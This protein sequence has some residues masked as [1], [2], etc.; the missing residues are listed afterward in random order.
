MKLILTATL[1]ILPFCFQAQFTPFLY[2][3]QVGARMN[4]TVNQLGAQLN[5]NMH[6]NI[7]SYGAAVDWQM[8]KL[9]SKWRLIHSVGTEIF[10]GEPIIQSGYN[11]TANY[12]IINK[13]QRILSLGVRS[14]VNAGSWYNNKSQYLLAL[15]GAH[16]SGHFIEAG[17]NAGHLF[18]RDAFG[19][20]NY[21][22]VLSG[23]FGGSFYLLDRQFKI[24][25]RIGSTYY[26]PIQSITQEIRWKNKFMIG[27][28]FGYEHYS[29]L[30]GA[31]LSNRIGIYSY[32]TQHK[33]FAEYQS[34]GAQIRMNLKAK[35]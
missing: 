35:N 5:T 3:S 33:N 6:S 27:Y 7:S 13:N 14:G 25:T 34:V 29:L 1:A 32:F 8:G 26:V 15:G 21:P 17:V 12:A 2:R 16:Y 30:V 18:Y 9:S 10:P 24:T 23:Y 4:D 22:V 19:N 31:Q 28:S 11:L 20:S